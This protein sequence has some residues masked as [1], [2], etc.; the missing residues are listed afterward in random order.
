[1]MNVIDLNH[2]E[3]TQAIEQNL[4]ERIH[5]FQKK[6]DAKQVF[7]W[8][9][10]HG[11]EEGHAFELGI[12]PAVESPMQFMQEI[13]Q[14]EHGYGHFI[15][16]DEPD[17]F[18]GSYE[19]N[20]V[21]EWQKQWQDGVENETTIAQLPRLVYQDWQLVPLA[22]FEIETVGFE[23]EEAENTFAQRIY[24]DILQ[25]IAQKYPDDVQGFVLE[26]H[27]SCLPIKWIGFE[28]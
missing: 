11:A 15:D 20:G 10:V 9:F 27:D 5:A 18:G 6:H 16:E 12:A 21:Y 7:A 22:D 2:A 8:L 26:M 23:A 17:D 14:R 28:T 13:A 24:G 4:I 3:I 1:M 25:A 19:L